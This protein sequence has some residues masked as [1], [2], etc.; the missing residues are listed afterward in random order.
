MK[1]S[2]TA[3]H[4]RLPLHERVAASS[5][6]E[7]EADLRLPAGL[8]V[9]RHPLFLLFVACCSS[10]AVHCLLFVACCSS[11]A[12]RR[13]LS[14]ACCPLLAV[15]CLLFVVVHHWVVASNCVWQ[16]VRW[17]SH[18]LL[19]AVRCLTGVKLLY[20]MELM[21]GEPDADERMVRCPLHDMDYPPMRW[22]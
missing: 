20:H 2:P 6:A 4:S 17:N 3:R 13:L 1:V 15:R 16:A 18:E 5:P 10:L 12:V 14:A 11:L 9:T 21:I 19:H 8:L 7:T 22:P